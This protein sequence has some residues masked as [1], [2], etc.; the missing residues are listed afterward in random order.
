MASGVYLIRHEFDALIGVNL[1]TRSINMQTLVS[2]F[3]FT[4][5]LVSI[6]TAFK[7]HEVSFSRRIFLFKNYAI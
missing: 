4:I 6:R 3:P 2:K 1:N 7:H 5:I